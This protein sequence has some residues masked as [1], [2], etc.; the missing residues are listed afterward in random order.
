MGVAPTTPRG[1]AAAALLS[2]LLLGLAFPNASIVVLLPVALVPLILALDGIRPGRAAFLG[3]LFGVAFW[4][5]TFP[6]IYH[7]VH[8]FGGLPAPLAFV[9]LL[10]AAVIPSVPMAAMTALA[11]LA[12]P[13]STVCGPA[14]PP[15]SAGSS[16]WRSG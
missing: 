1:R 11:A 10:V 5:T 2:G 12:A 13:R 7:V 9:A 8:R 6:W 3:G 16:A 4:L 15:S 14:A